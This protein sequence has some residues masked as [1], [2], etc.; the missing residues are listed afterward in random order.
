MNLTRSKQLKTHFVH[1]RLGK[2]TGVDP[3]HDMLAGLLLLLIAIANSC[4][5]YSY[6]LHCCCSVGASELSPASSIFGPQTW[7][8]KLTQL[9]EEA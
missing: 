5:L 2:Y 6:C 3:K 7:S 9:K 1:T 8:V 4:C